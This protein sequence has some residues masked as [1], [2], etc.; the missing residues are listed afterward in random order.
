MLRKTLTIL[1]LI[2]LLLSAGLWGAQA[3]E[4]ILIYSSSLPGNVQNRPRILESNKKLHAQ[5]MQSSLQS[6]RWG[7]WELKN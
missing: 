3:H 6:S 5:V 1:S 2:G 4:P 7:R